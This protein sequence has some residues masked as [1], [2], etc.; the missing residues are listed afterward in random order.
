MKPLSYYL[1]QLSAL[2][3]FIDRMDDEQVRELVNGCGSKGGLL[4]LDLVPDDFM[5][6]DVSPACN[7]HDVG[8]H[9]GDTMEEKLVSD[10]LF[11]IYMVVLNHFDQG[12]TMITKAVRYNIIMKYFVAVSMGGGDAFWSDKKEITV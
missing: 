12:E 1:R 9:L 11:L 2:N 10:L 3:D 8:Y 7:K 5:G 6:L 4:G